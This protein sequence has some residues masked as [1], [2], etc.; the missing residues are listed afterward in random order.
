M[1]IYSRWYHEKVS[2]PTATKGGQYCSKQ[3][4]HRLSG[5]LTIFNLFRTELQFIGPHPDHCW[6][7]TNLALLPTPSFIWKR[8]IGPYCYYYLN[9]RLK[10]T[11][12]IS[13]GQ[14]CYA[15]KCVQK[16]VFNWNGLLFKKKT[17]MGEIPVRTGGIFLCTSL[18]SVWTGQ[19][20]SNFGFSSK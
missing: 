18:K 3:L 13:L 5:Q 1:R 8:G 14:I 9:G 20:S 7:Q 17:P 16:Y 10:A 19:C 4:E 11:L 2:S 15:H 6:S 12:G